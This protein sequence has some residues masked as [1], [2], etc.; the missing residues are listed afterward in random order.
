MKKLFNYSFILLIVF[1]GC[2]KGGDPDE[3]TMPIIPLDERPILFG[4][5]WSPN[6]TIASW[7]ANTRDTSLVSYKHKNL[8]VAGMIQQGNVT[9][10]GGGAKNITY[11]GLESTETT[12]TRICLFLE[13][14][15][16]IATLAGNELRADYSEGVQG[17]TTFNGDTYLIALGAYKGTRADSYYYKIPAMGGKPTYH[18]LPKTEYGNGYAWYCGTSKGL[19]VGKSELVN[20][21]ICFLSIYRDESW[22]DDFRLEVPGY[23][24]LE[25]ESL[26]MPND[27]DMIAVVSANKIG[28]GIN[29]VFYVTINIDT[30]AVKVYR[31]DIPAGGYHF[32]HSAYADGK[33]YVPAYENAI[34][35]CSYFVFTLH[36]AAEEVKFKKIDLEVKDVPYGS[37]YRLKTRGT[38]VYVTGDQKGLACYWK[39]GKL[40]DIKNDD[41]SQSIIDDI[42]TFD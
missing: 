27:H 25:P 13:K 30:K 2:K 29:E 36:K 34:N 7:F 19:V 9:S 4:R 18:K 1:A 10:P 16:P 39:N 15:T 14:S 11:Y 33:V 5:T 40:I 28:A 35:K 6:H 42:I 31:P 22:I 24:N 32:G 17:K 26:L 3:G 41:A 12:H 23:Q 8:V 37:A 20:N 21:K 38:N